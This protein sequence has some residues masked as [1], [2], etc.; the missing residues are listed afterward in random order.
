[1]EVSTI[2]F[3]LDGGGGEQW[4]YYMGRTGCLGD[5][6]SNLVAIRVMYNTMARE[7]MYGFRR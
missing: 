1:V 5:V 4:L 3:G 2:D 7:I 6:S